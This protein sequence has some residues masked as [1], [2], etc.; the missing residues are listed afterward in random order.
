MCTTYTTPFTFDT[1][2]SSQRLLT[3]LQC[4]ILSE[5]HSFF[6]TAKEPSTKISQVHQM[7][8][9]SLI[10][11]IDFKLV[12]CKL[13]F[14]TTCK[15]FLMWYNLGTVWMKPTT[16]VVY[17]KYNLF[18][19]HKICLNHGWVV[20]LSYYSIIQSLTHTARYSLFFLTS[21][22]STLSTRERTMG[23]ELRYKGHKRSF[24]WYWTGP[25]YD[26]GTRLL[27]SLGLCGLDEEGS[28]DRPQC[29]L[30]V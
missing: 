12:Y 16:G 2:L 14:N 29:H 30:K 25:V 5:A 11:T 24:P 20:G 6:Q 27:R 19:H 28:E 4:L 22:L 18:E 13:C 21:K 1:R 8:T 17:T 3:D 9:L 26:M 15:M 7:H 23:M 10:L